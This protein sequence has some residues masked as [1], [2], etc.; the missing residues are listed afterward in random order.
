MI[1][2]QV[3]HEYLDMI[4]VCYD[5]EMFYSR[6]PG[7]LAQFLGTSKQERDVLASFFVFF[8]P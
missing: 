7:D 1:R 5:E 4:F 3:S 8:C 6:R 2:V